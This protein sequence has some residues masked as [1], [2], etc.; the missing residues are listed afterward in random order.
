MWGKRWEGRLRARDSPPQHLPSPQG[1][2]TS[3]L[4]GSFSLSALGSKK[5]G[6]FWR[7]GVKSISC[8]RSAWY[9]CS[10]CGEGTGVGVH[11]LASPSCANQVCESCILGSGC[12][13]Q[14]LRL[15]L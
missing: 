12:A 10:A 3:G 8:F 14:V 13:C 11:L 5:R 6:Q 7:R 2:S 15:G 1:L 9:V 4:E